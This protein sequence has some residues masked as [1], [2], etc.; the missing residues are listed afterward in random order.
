MK[1]RYQFINLKVLA[2]MFLICKVSYTFSTKQVVGGV[3]NLKYDFQEISC[4]VVFITCQA[5]TVYCNILYLHSDC[6]WYER[7]VQERKKKWPH[8]ATNETLD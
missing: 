5:K 3:I 6:K 7:D 2:R 8:F 4:K 1:V